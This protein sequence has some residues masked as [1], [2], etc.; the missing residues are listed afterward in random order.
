MRSRLKYSSALAAAA[1]ALACGAP[2]ASATTFGSS[3]DVFGVPTIYNAQTV[4]L[5]GFA[6]AIPSFHLRYH[7]DTGQGSAAAGGTFTVTWTTTGTGTTFTGGLTAAN[8][9]FTGGTGGTCNAATMNPP[10]SSPTVSGNTVTVSAIVAAAG[11][12]GAGCTVFLFS[13]TALATVGSPALSVTGL[14]NL[15]PASGA[16]A[17][18]STGGSAPSAVFG[19]Q[20]TTTTFQGA[21]ILGLPT[22]QDVITVAVTADNGAAT[23]ID[24]NP[25]IA[26]SLNS[27]NGFAVSAIGT[28]ALVDLTGTG[29]STP[30]LQFQ[31][32]SNGVLS[33]STA[34]S[35][36]AL[37]VVNNSTGQFDAVNANSCCGNTTNVFANN[38]PLALAVN[39]SFLGDF[40]TI[41]SAYLRPG[42][43][44]ASSPTPTVNGAT[45]NVEQNP[46]PNSFSSVCTGTPSGGDIPSTPAPTA[47][48]FTNLT[49]AIPNST[50]S[51]NGSL[52][53]NQTQYAVCVVT[54]NTNLIADTFQGPGVSGAGGTQAF[55]VASNGV[56]GVSTTITVAVP[57]IATPIAVLTNVKAGFDISYAGTKAVFPMV[58]SSSTGRPSSF[59]LVN[60]GLGT[61][62][63]YAILQKDGGVPIT[64]PGSFAAMTPF[65]AF[66]VIADSIAFQGGQTLG[67]NNT[68]TLLTPAPPGALQIA[69]FLNDPNGDI[70]LTLPGL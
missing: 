13:P 52:A 12:T 40:Q 23:N 3:A 50:N 62:P 56:A 70:V 19:T 63:M 60:T 9:L 49:F 31:K 47:A 25:Q 48:G 30:G 54:N 34:A 20:N 66:F 36:G 38:K 5:N 68:I 24:S 41:V 55:G 26:M 58:F 28:G 37:T 1:I 59:R 51:V 53:P 14:N 45:P 65:S 16:A 32:V 27:A 43:N 11:G 7:S 61:F 17:G 46:N 69:H 6:A 42:N 2:G 15:A 10:A 39:A 21:G 35:L 33:T 44:V 64:I 4:A 22:L 18:T 57:G 8:V 67:L 29:G